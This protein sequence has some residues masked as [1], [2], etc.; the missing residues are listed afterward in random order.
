MKYPGDVSEGVL[1][2][3]ENR[4]VAEVVL[5]GTAVLAHVANTGRLAELLYPGNRVLVMRSRQEGRKTSHTLI[6]AYHNGGWVSIVSAWANPL[7]REAAAAGLLPGLAEY[8]HWKPEVRWGESR[9][10]FRL[11]AT[12]AAGAKDCL[13]EVKGVTLLD[14]DNCARFPDAPTSRGVRHL[15]ELT[16]AVQE[17]Y[18]AAVIFVVKR[19]GA[20]AFAPN[21]RT[22][23]AFSSALSEAGARG[24]AIYAVACG[25]DEQGIAPVRVL[26]VRL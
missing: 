21:D 3:R 4:F 18:R 2:R 1:V 16:R 9:L 26:P 13:V 19:S 11:S 12:G 25:V 20:V 10:D 14:A 15:G 22:D 17:G 7:A 24:V 6:G 5:A 8:E 23:P